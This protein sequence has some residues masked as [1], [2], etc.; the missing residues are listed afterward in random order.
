MLYNTTRFGQIEVPEDKI[1]TFKDGLIAF[2]IC[3]KFVILKHKPE[4]S[5]FWLQSLEIPEL[6]FTMLF[7]FQFISNY[8]PS[9][10]SEDLKRLNCDNQSDLEFYNMV[11]IPKDPSKMTINLLSPIVVNSKAGIAIQAVLNDALYSVSHP[12]IQ[13]ENSSSEASK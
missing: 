13:T 12:L 5:F 3:K 1:I 8:N 6:A 11:V 2:E 4:S 9:L 7:P 10:T